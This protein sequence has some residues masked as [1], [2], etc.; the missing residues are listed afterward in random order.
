[1]LRK[2]ILNKRIYTLF[3]IQT[4][5]GNAAKTNF[6]LFVTIKVAE[7]K[8]SVVFAS[9]DDGLCVSLIGILILKKGEILKQI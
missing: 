5:I 3:L 1:M 9:I 8:C 6:V 2:R 7:T 4:W